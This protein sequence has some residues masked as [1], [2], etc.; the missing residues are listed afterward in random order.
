M[1]GAAYKGVGAG[2]RRCSDE[3]IDDMAREAREMLADPRGETFIARHYD[4]PAAVPSRHLLAA[5]KELIERR[6]AAR[7]SGARRRKGSRDAT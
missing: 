7:K 3:E 2:G 4:F 5:L 6:V 1:S